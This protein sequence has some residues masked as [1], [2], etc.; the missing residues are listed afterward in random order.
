MFFI[1]GRIKKILED[2][3]RK[4]MENSMSIHGIKW[5]NCGYGD[6]HLLNEDDANWDDFSDDK[7]WGGRDKHSWFRFQ[8]ELPKEFKGKHVMLKISTDREGWDAINPQFTAWIDGKLQHG[9]DVNH[10][11]LS[12]SESGEPGRNYCIDLY[13]YGGTEEGYSKFFAEMFA[14]NSQVEKLYYD[15][16]VPLE[17]ACLLHEEDK[18]RIDT[19]NCLE[20]AVNLLDLRDDNSQL[21]YRSVDDAILYLEK[22]LYQSDIIG[23]ENFSEL[24]VGH[25]H[26]DVAW[27]WSLRQTRE[28]AVRSFS[29]VISL[30][31]EFPEYI[32][33]SSQPQLYQF[34]KQ[35]QPKLYG[36]IK[37][38]VA[39]GRWEPEG[40]MWVEADC[41]LISGESL[42]RQIIFGKKFFKDEFGV[43]N[44]IL[45]LPDVF[46]YS[47]AL[48]QIMKKSGIKYFM[49]TKISWNEFNKIPYDTFLWRGIDGTEI[50]TQFVT[51]QEYNKKDPVNYTTYNGEINPSYVLGCWQRYQQKN[52]NNEVLN[53]FGFGDGGGGP[54]REM[55][56][57]ARRMKDGL[58]GM[59]KVRVGKAI[60]FFEKLEKNTALNPKLPKWVG[61]LYLEFHRGTYTSMARNK[62]Y[63][64]KA[65]F[66]NQD[67][68]WLSVMAEQ[69]NGL[70][71]PKEKIHDF[72]EVTLL[73][74]FHDIIPGSAI[75]EVYET[76]KEQYE[77]LLENGEKMIDRALQSIA[78]RVKTDE[79]SFFVFN[80]LGF[81][82][83]D[84]VTV[85]LPEGWDNAEV[86]DGRKALATQISYDGKLIFYAKNL[87]AKGYK[88]FKAIKAP[89]QQNNSELVFHR[90]CEMENCFFKLEMDES[91]NLISVYDKNNERQVL[92]SNS[93]GNLLQVFEDK[94]MDFDA[95][96]LDIYYQEKSWEINDVT[97]IKLI[98]DG[99]LRKA[100][101]IKKK[102]FN[103]TIVQILFM[104]SDIN[105]IDFSTKIDWKE[106]QA[107][108]KSAFP[109]EINSDKAV[110]DIQFGNVE[111]PTHW[112]TS[113][114][115]A[116]FEVCAHK[117]A[118]LSEGGYGVA[119]LNDCK[120]G[121]DIKDSVMRISLLKSGIYPNPDA[122]KELHEFTY[123]L[124][125]HLGDYKEAQVDKMAYCINCPVYTVFQN[126]HDGNLPEEISFLS[127]D[128]S[129]VFLD[130][131][132][133]SERGNEYIIRLYENHN[134][135]SRVSCTSYKNIKSI[136]ECDLLENNISEVNVKGNKFEFSI[137]PFEIKTF[138][139][140][141]E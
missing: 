6:F 94:P 54:T 38:M 101:Q 87:P 97:E 44:K 3:R 112:N 137:K 23:S 135:H 115:L 62:R 106:K 2:L 13:A 77:Q 133:K 88:V 60:D 17:A 64:R 58:P 25:T 131:I 40:S 127:I 57:Y 130:T 126:P 107:F 78:E 104:Y 132:K 7:A 76:S 66:M 61:E 74:Q 117:W 16:T 20:S 103:S 129:N 136:A 99:P 138:K 141:L 59:P 52:I 95:W 98:E 73:N 4:T 84:I 79:N 5:K 116:K 81:I 19:L 140:T 51:T 75:K 110:Y 83:D 47:A 43:D 29:T 89:L 14:L 18:R 90:G 105:R 56:E 36:E 49:T 12:L 45:W 28:K 96:N 34:V 118:D 48:P 70:E 65:E 71:Y 50:L 10:R 121:Y 53:C 72:W 92:K 125:P 123:S 1:E 85:D 109:V 46:G 134:Q 124:Y 114:D 33:M 30:M 8:V 113:W 55:L 108:L 120:Y 32:F 67:L 100:V 11:L 26:I 128:R 63:N 24:C 86:Y 37:K 42:V 111:R 31:K 102:Y 27:L 122:D 80:Q 139:I 39:E 41:N 68:E 22:E 91:G 15:I 82:R 69:L 35:D 119:L 9:L 93:R 21:F